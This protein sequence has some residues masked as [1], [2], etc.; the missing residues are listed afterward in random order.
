[1]LRVL[2]Y[3]NRHQ[4][5]DLFSKFDS[6]KQSWLVSDLRTKLELQSY[7]LEKQDYYVDESVL[8]ASDL[9]KLLL[10]RLDPEI[11]LVS[12]AF[13]RASLRAILEQNE[14]SLGF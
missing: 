7:L 13:A 2:K 5:T 11:R 12:D 8:R 1:M 9:W 14:S 4:I 3:K 6:R 10:K